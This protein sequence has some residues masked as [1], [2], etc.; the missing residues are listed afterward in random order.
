MRSAGRPSAVRVV[1]SG[2]TYAV[3]KEALKNKLL[4]KLKLDGVETPVIEIPEADPVLLAQHAAYMASTVAPDRA[5]LLVTLDGLHQA[6]EFQSTDRSCCC[7]LVGLSLIAS[8]PLEMVELFLRMCTTFALAPDNVTA[9]NALLVAP[10]AQQVELASVILPIVLEGQ[11]ALTPLLFD[12]LIGAL[13]TNG[14]HANAVRVW[15][16]FSASPSFEPLPAT[17]Q[18][19]LQSGIRL[20]DVSFSQQM[21]SRL[22]KIRGSVSP[23]GWLHYLDFLFRS[24]CS[25]PIRAAWYDFGQTAQLDAAQIKYFF[26]AAEELVRL[27]RWRVHS[28][29]MLV[30]RS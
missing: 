22:H 30:S 1:Q 6:K 19:L 12:R 28:S 17:V 7:A 27:L 2:R 10:A 23:A 9:L 20:E 29:L 8:S 5:T 14:Q 13:S 21:M 18:A 4:S 11:L 25:L 16:V 26:L 15:G 24:R 3:R